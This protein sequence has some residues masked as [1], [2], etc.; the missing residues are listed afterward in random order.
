[1]VEAGAA[2]CS[3]RKE[4]ARYAEA[5]HAQFCQPSRSTHNMCAMPTAY[6]L[7]LVTLLKRSFVTIRLSEILKDFWSE[8]PPADLAQ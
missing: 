3:F 6:H 2:S 7:R 5:A 1:M 4:R 8:L